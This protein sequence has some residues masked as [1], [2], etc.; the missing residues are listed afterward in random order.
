MV[1]KNSKTEVQ[2]RVYSKTIRQLEKQQN[3]IQF[4][5]CTKTIRQLGL[6][7]YERIV[8]SGFAFDDYS[9]LVYT[10]HC[11]LQVLHSDWLLNRCLFVMV[12]VWE[13]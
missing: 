12:N 9:L 7:V 10:R 4:R 11:L 3:K 6:V 1:E 13:K 8:N 5:V 2:F